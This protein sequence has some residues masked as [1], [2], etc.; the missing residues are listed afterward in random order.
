MRRE[1]AN[2]YIGTC[3]KGQ[4]CPYIHDETK[5]A[6]CKELLFKQLCPQGPS[7]NLSHDLTPERTPHCLH[8]QKGSCAKEKCPF[9]HVRVSL[10]APVCAIFPV[11]GYCEEGATCPNKHVFECPEFSNTGNC[12]NTRCKLPHIHKAANIRRQVVSK[13]E[14]SD[15]S[16][17]ED[18]QM[19]DSDDIDSDEAEGF[20]KPE[21]GDADM[22]FA[23]QKDFVQM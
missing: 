18:D 6:A 16:S 14:E 11:Y 17:D 7:C 21:D 8:F 9:A 1:E 5:V 4:R 22:D 13:D 15:I 2:F 23:E 10:T 12:P 19:I 20:F 3:T